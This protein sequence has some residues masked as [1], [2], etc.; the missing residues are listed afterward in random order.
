M[1]SNSSSEQHVSDEEINDTES[2]GKVTFKSLV[3]Y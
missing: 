3:C 1:A 2:E